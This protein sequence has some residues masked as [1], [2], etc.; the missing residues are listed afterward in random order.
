MNG[1]LTSSLRAIFIFVFMLI[2]TRTIGRK[3]ISKM[4]FFNFVVAITLGSVAA[5]VVVGK[6][7]TTVSITAILIV[8]TLLAIATGFLTIKSQWFRKA[9]NSEPVVMIANG[10]IIEENME[11]V[12]LGINDLLMELREKSVFNISDVEFALME[13]NGELTVLKKSQKEPLTPSDLKIDT[14]YHGLTKDLIVD[15]EIL[16][17]N[18]L[19]IKLDNQWLKEAIAREGYQSPREIFYAGLDTQGNLYISPRQKGHEEHGQYGLE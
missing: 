7:G 15:G 14:P 1:L 10:R 17:N 6:D 16:E 8:F 18:L 9:I 3:L 4:T 2:L 13:T 19:D 12:R 5:I 11:K